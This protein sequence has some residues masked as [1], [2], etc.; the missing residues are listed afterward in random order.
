MSSLWENAQ[1]LLT[2]VEEA[3]LAVGLKINN[4]KTKALQLRKLA[5]ETSPAASFKVQSGSIGNVGD[6]C[7]LGSYVRDCEKDLSQRI[8]QAWAATNR[9]WK[10]WKAEGIDRQMKRNLFR[11]TVESVLLY[12]SPCWALTS[13]QSKR[14]DGTYTRLLKK[15]LN[16]PWAQH[17]TNKELYGNLKPPS[18]TVSA[19]RI[20]FAGH[21]FRRIDQPV[22]DL[23][24]FEAD[25]TFRTG[26]HSRMSFVKQLKSDLCQ[27][28]KIEIGKI[29]SEE[30]LLENRVATRKAAKTA[31]AFSSSQAQSRRL[32]TTIESCKKDEMT[33]HVI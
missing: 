6:F 8:G 19:R 4:E 28:S 26:Q 24:L 17:I 32:K 25:G 12:G 31:S 21:C 7:Y 5:S 30:Q 11:S 20:M 27:N 33:F 3:A 22:H 2:Q 13:L 15:A 10:V 18:V 9:L 29:L 23:V 1:T 14:L 16:V